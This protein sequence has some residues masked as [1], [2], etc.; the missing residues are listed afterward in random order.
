MFYVYFL[1]D[2]A[3]EL[4]YVGRSHLPQQRRGT[5]QRRHPEA[6]V[7]RMGLEAYE[8]F[9]E[10]SDRELAAIIQYSP[11]FNRRQASSPANKGKK[12]SEETL[13]KMRKAAEGRRPPSKLGFRHSVESRAKMSAK[14]TGKKH[15][16]ETRAKIAASQQKSRNQEK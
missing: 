11:P 2:A 13:A 5:F 4:L 7:A 10:A 3:D 12:H 9:E 6:T 16:A 8:T 15:T 14:H 1:F